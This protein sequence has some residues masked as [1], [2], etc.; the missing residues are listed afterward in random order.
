M[1]VKPSIYGNVEYL[2]FKNIL[3]FDYIDLSKKPTN[4]EEVNYV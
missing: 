4:V 3:M 2:R 1:A